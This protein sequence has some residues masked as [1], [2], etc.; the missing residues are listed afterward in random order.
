M[1][2]IPHKIPLKSLCYDES[3]KQAVHAVVF[4][5]IDTYRWQ[6][7]ESL[8]T[9]ITEMDWSKDLRLHRNLQHVTARSRARLHLIAVGWAASSR[10]WVPDSAP[11]YLNGLGNIVSTV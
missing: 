7:A 11:G 10:L 3:R 9:K 8:A 4:L 6:Q 2:R 5:G 1:F